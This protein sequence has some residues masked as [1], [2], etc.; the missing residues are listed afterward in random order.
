MSSWVHWGRSKNNANGQTI[1]TN[2]CYKLLLQNITTNY[3]GQVRLHKSN[4][5]EQT[6]YKLLLQSTTLNYYYS[7]LLRTMEVKLGQTR[8]MPIDK[9]LLPACP[10]CL[11]NLTSGHLCLQPVATQQ[12]SMLNF[13]NFQFWFFFFNFQFFLS[14]VYISWQAGAL[15]VITSV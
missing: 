7:L 2:H 11:H 13:V 14:L 1:T 5:N 4:A 15:V 8:T 10:P 6:F 3:G 9:L 12:L